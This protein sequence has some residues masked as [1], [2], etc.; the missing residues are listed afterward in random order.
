MQSKTTK[1]ETSIKSLNQQIRHIGKLR[2]TNRKQEHEEAVTDLLQKGSF[3]AIAIKSGCSESHIRKV[4]EKP[5]K[6]ITNRELFSELRKHE[7]Q[8]FGLQD[9]TSLQLPSLKY[10]GK[11]FLIGS[12]KEV[13]QKYLRSPEFHDFGTASKSTV[14]RALSEVTKPESKFPTFE[15]L[16]KY[17]ENV[18]YKVRALQSAKV[19][20]VAASRLKV[21]S[22]TLCVTDTEL[23]GTSEKFCSIA[24]Y[25][26]CCIHCGTEKLREKILATNDGI[27][28]QKKMIWKEWRKTGKNPHGEETTIPQKV[29]VKGTV[30]DCVELLLEELQPHALH[31]FHVTWNQFQ[32]EHLRKNLP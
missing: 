24:C 3:S 13:Y 6:K 20:G 7:I 15:A 11:R 14:Y 23:A 5:E 18:S 26:H 31:V 29:E 4:C 1:E 32:I 16:C 30:T 8:S 19:K 17:D 9:D 10:V 27:V 22:D 12:H 21:L 2:K 28:Q 25:K